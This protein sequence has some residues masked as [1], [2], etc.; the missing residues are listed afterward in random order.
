MRKKRKNT[1][2]HRQY[3]IFNFGSFLPK[4]ASVKT[5]V[6]IADLVKSFLTSVYYLFAKFGFDTAE[7]EPCKVCRYQHT[8]SWVIS[9]AL[10]SFQRAHI[11]ADIILHG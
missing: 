4:D 9:S 10:I 8:P 11:Q 5:H 6:N 7:N 2:K 1:Y 3:L